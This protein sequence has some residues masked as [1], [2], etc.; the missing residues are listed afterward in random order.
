ADL[1]EAQSRMGVQGVQLPEIRC[2]GGRTRPDAVAVVLVI[3]EED[4]VKSASDRPRHVAS[5]ERKRAQF[6]C[7]VAASDVVVKRQGGTTASVLNLLVCNRQLG[8]DCGVLPCP[9]A[10]NFI[11]DF[12]QIDL[13]THGREVGFY[14]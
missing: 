13:V 6:G 4:V 14:P 8:A 12:P 9:V 7:P 3:G 5:R 11:S 10:I 1:A 2:P